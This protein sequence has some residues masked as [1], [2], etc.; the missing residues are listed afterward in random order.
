MRQRDRN[1][2]GDGLD[3]V[4]HGKRIERAEFRKSVPGGGEER[5]IPS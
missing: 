2:G 3:V 5:D 4:G 1:E